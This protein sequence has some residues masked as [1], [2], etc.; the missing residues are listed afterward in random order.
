[1]SF[2]IPKW[3]F[4]FIVIALLIPILSIESIV[5]WTIFIFFSSKFIKISKNTYLST[6]LKIA[7]CSGYCTLAIALG[8]F[9]NF[10]VLK[11]TTYFMN[12]IL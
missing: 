2:S 10:L 5:P 4:I 8:I 11:G 3:C 7:K 1:M 12:N 6:K 9:F